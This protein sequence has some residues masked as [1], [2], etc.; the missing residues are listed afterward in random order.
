MN[1]KLITVGK[2]SAPYLREGEHEYQNRLKHYMKFERID[3]NDLKVPQKTSPNEVKKKEAEIILKHLKPSDEIVLLD[4]NGKNLSSVEF[5]K[6]FEK[7]T[8]SGHKNL[9]FLVGGAF[10][11]DKLIYERAN[12]KIRLSSLTFSHQ[13]VRLFFLEQLYRAGT[14]LKRE[15]YHHQ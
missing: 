10:G 1:V 3:L 14:I 13:M 2:T 9:V 15:K 8:L 6:W 5:S 11:F 12:D 4:E 7:R